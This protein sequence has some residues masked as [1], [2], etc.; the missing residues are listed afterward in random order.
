MGDVS[1]FGASGREHRGHQRGGEEA[2]ASTMLAG[3]RKAM[4]IGRWTSEEAK[5]C[6]STLEGAAQA[7][8]VR[9]QGFIHGEWR[10]ATDG[11]TLSVDNPATGETVQQVAKMGARETVEAI[12]SARD[13]FTTWKRK[14][15][16]ERAAVLWRWHDLI[17][18]NREHL[19]AILTS[20]NGK[21]I[22]EAR[23][24][25]R[26]GMGS[27][28]WS[29][30]EAKR[31]RGDVLEPPMRNR[32][33][34]V[35]KQPVGVVGAITPWNF[36]MSMVTRKVAP[37]LAVGCT[38]VLKPS[39]LTPLSA[40]ALAE[41]ANRAG[42]PPGVLNVVMG[43]AP[44]IG[45]TILKSPD[46]KKIGFTGST[47]VGKMLMAGAAETVKK[48]SLELGGNAPL[49]VFDDADLE[50]AAAAAATSAFR[51]AGQT[52]ICAARILVQE[53][54]HDRFVELLAHHANSTR[55]GNGMDS[56]VT[57]GPLIT[58][59]AIQRVDEHVSDAVAKGAKVVAGG[60][61][62][63]G[64]GNFY[65]PTVLS[66]VSLDTRVH[67]EETF[68]PLAPVFKFKDEEEAIRIANDTPYGLAAYFFTSDLARGW[69]VAEALDYGMV[70][71]NEVGFT[72]E[73]IPF[74]GVKESGLGREGS[75]YG[76]DDFLEIKFVCMGLGYEKR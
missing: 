74:G 35:M 11:A 71:L 64:V 38:V 40:L 62:R 46:V 73:S 24:E 63:D 17:H 43:D 55:L 19:A 29:A 51:N 13:A 53:G 50:K 23:A 61:K 59:A 58:P 75:S 68:G 2:K 37:A 41:L 72:H 30:E 27:I 57:T 48:V 1:E 31:V 69:R 4:P 14:T 9:A 15:A 44:A 16:H 26:S 22:S 39:E 47:A 6:A 67:M 34:V 45:R 20:E 3:W 12:A 60:K 70:G 21:P 36:P 32:R 49:L 33:N 54:V 25:I 42:M 76:L 28:T 10:D 65:H 7:G 5:A 18:E 52:C 56:S 8:L 66:G